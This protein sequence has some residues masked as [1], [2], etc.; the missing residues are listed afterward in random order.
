MLSMSPKNS[1]SAGESFSKAAKGKRHTGPTTHATRGSGAIERERERL[2]L[3]MQLAVA[4]MSQVG[5]Q[6]IGPAKPKKKGGVSSGGGAWGGK[7]DYGGDGWGGGG[8]ISIRLVPAGSISVEMDGVRSQERGGG[9]VH[10]GSLKGGSLGS[11]KGQRQARY[12]VHARQGMQPQV[13]AGGADAQNML[14]LVAQPIIAPPRPEEPPLMAKTTAAE[15]DPVDAAGCEAQQPAIEVV[16]SASVRMGHGAQNTANAEA[17]S[18]GGAGMDRGAV[19]RGGGSQDEGRRDP[20]AE[21]QSND[22]EGAG[23]VKP[24]PESPLFPPRI[25]SVGAMAAGTKSRKGSDKVR[26]QPTDGASAAGHKHQKHQ[27]AHHHSGLSESMNQAGFSFVSLGNC[28]PLPSAESTLAKHHRSQNA[29]RDQQSS[30]V[31]LFSL[32][33]CIILSRSH[34]LMPTNTTLTPRDV[35]ANIRDAPPPCSPDGSGFRR[36]TTMLPPTAK[37]SNSSKASRLPQ[38]PQFP[39]TPRAQLPS[40]RRRLRRI[41]V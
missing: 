9:A 6:V 15:G 32:V 7:G 35:E 19:D 31:R 4:G 23:V 39:T 11:K 38:I 30:N 26:Q 17:G 2:A 18:S 33:F 36:T 22:A 10:G 16:E 20:A 13:E 34:I 12:S 28:A 27:S 14:L 3:E 29:A 1:Q 25:P 21:A 8:D 41:P 5:A 24:R 40:S 37:S